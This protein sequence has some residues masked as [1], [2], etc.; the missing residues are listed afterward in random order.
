M[1]LYL[2]D[3]TKGRGLHILID[4][5]SIVFNKIPNIKLILPLIC[6]KKN[7]ISRKQHNIK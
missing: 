6:Q 2:G 1:L 7:M 5:L 3:L 4:S